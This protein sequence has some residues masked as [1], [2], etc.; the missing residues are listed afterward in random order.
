MTEY[1]PYW[2]AT[3][4]RGVI[5]LLT[6][7]VIIFCSASRS[8]MLL[9]PLAIVF[10]VMA[11][12]AYVV[13]DSAIALA[14]S[15]MLPHHHLGRNRTAHPGGH[16]CNHRHWL[17]HNQLRGRCPNLVSIPRRST[18]ALRRYCRVSCCTGY[19]RVSQ[20]QMVLCDRSHRS[21]IL[22]DSSDLSSGNRTLFGL[23]AL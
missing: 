21:T 14:S 10:S 20:F 17:L 4:V 11:L 19:G 5:A 1:T 12:A 22:C 2:G 9:T 7:V 16:W 8:S 6:G 18:S 3:W 23:A 13:F 15:F